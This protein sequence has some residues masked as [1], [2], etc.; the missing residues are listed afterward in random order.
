[1]V[2]QRQQSPTFHCA[3]HCATAWGPSREEAAVVLHRTLHSLLRNNIDLFGER[4]EKQ[5]IMATFYTVKKKS[6]FVFAK[7]KWEMISILNVFP[8]HILTCL[9]FLSLITT[10]NESFKNEDSNCFSHLYSSKQSSLH[11]VSVWGKTQVLVDAEFLWE[12]KISLFL[13]F[14]ILVHD[15][16]VCSFEQTWGYAKTC[17]LDLLISLPTQ[18]N[19]ISCFSFAQSFVLLNHSIFPR[20]FFSQCI[21]SCCFK[22]AKQLRSAVL[23]TVAVARPM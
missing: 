21:V 23:G 6:N 22:M 12:N 10:I 14:A 20:K 1:M 3:L 13:F 16:K 19:D 8:L 4:K 15:M 2:S 17:H 5:S 7:K 9:S 18:R 11:N